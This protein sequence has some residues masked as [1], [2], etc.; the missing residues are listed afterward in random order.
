MVKYS[1]GKQIL[2]DS[3]TTN[4]LLYPV[5][6]WLVL[7][8]GSFTGWIPAREHGLMYSIDFTGSSRILYTGA[9]VLVTMIFLIIGLFRIIRFSR[10][11]SRGELVPGKS[12]TMDNMNG[13]G[14]GLILYTFSYSGQEFA[15]KASVLVSN[16]YTEYLKQNRKISVLVNPK[17]PK[18]SCIR[19]LLDARFS[20]PSGVSG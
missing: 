3:V 5:L 20:P 11:C 16:K 12:L 9:A 15:G 10:L 4:C 13:S 18:C 14:A 17:R 19:E 2:N 8:F 1:F 7:L 6:I